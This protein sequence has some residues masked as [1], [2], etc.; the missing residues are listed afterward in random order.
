M[1]EAVAKFIKTKMKDWKESNINLQKAIVSIFDCIV[2]NC[3]NIN[4]RTI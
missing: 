3:E 1:L 2:K 4:K